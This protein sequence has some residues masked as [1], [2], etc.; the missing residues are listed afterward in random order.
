MVRTYDLKV[1]RLAGVGQATV[2]Q[3]GTTP[4]G[5]DL[6]DLAVDDFAGQPEHHVFGIAAIQTGLQHKS[7]APFG[8]S[9]HVALNDARRSLPGD[10]GQRGF[11]AIQI[12][13]G[14][15]Q[16]QSR[17]LGV[18]LSLHQ[19]MM[20]HRVQTIAE[21]NHRSGLRLFGDGQ[22][23]V[24]CGQLAFDIIQKSQEPTSYFPVLPKI[25]GESR[26]KSALPRLTVIPNILDN[27]SVF[28][29]CSDVT[30]SSYGHFS[31]ERLSSSRAETVTERPLVRKRL[32]RAS[33]MATERCCPPVHPMAMVT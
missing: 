11:M 31:A 25:S 19:N 13:D 33:L 24:D 4:S 22:F 5:L 29:L 7:R 30:F 15:L 28:S 3:K 23:V 12:L 20:I 6:G 21:S 17:I 27:H 16:P 8:D 9:N 14:V 10:R 26:G 32:A 2:R 1:A 18:K